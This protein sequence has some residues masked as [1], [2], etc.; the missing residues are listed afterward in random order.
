MYAG[1]YFNYIECDW[2]EIIYQ[3]A[4][5]YMQ[6]GHEDDFTYNLFNRNRLDIQFGLDGF[7]DI[8]YIN[9]ITGYEQYYHD[10]LGF[11]RLLYI[12]K[13]EKENYF[14]QYRIVNVSSNK[15]YPLSIRW[16]SNNTFS[17]D[18][19]KTETK[20]YNL[21]AP[22][23]YYISTDDEQTLLSTKDN[24]PLMVEGTTYT[25]SLIQAREKS[26][27]NI[28]DTEL[29]PLRQDKDIV[30]KH[31]NGYNVVYSRENN[32][33][34]RWPNEASACWRSSYELAETKDGI[35]YYYGTVHYYGASE[36]K[37]QAELLI[38]KANKILGN[39]NN[40]ENL[41]LKIEQGEELNNTELDNLQTY[42]D[43]FGMLNR[44]FDVEKTYVQEQ[45][46]I[47]NNIRIAQ[48]T[49]VQQLTAQLNTLA[50]QE[51][52]YSASI[53]YYQQMIQAASL[54]LCPYSIYF[55]QSQTK[56]EED[57]YENIEYTYNGFPIY[58]SY[59]DA[60]AHQWSS[61][62]VED[63]SSLLFWIDFWDADSLGLGQYSVPAIG[64]RPKVIN[65]EGIKVLIYQDVPDL[66]FVYEEDYKDSLL[67]N[68]DGYNVAILKPG[69]PFRE[70]LETRQIDRSSRSTTAQEEIDNLLYNYGYCNEDSTITTIPVYYLEPNNIIS[71]KDEQQIVN[72]YYILNKMTIPLSYNGTMQNNCIRVPERIY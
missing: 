9:G 60:I 71:A 25:L 22:Q 66:I 38:N 21:L 40:Y 31:I 27:Q 45:I 20:E 53:E 69:D 65:N 56:N 49:K 32:T 47:Q 28:I 57:F 48:T 55:D 7:K 39:L 30:S 72:G 14:S 2:R 54:A 8:H 36:L 5:D 6:Y 37:A 29:T 35:K 50:V 70:Y 51:A 16:N 41:L 18:A 64:A 1:K 67:D 43:I 10:M 33:I 3:M 15:K 26:I 52:G 68:Y 61:R 24:S 42:R 17:Y 12:P 11:W 46:G 58:T 13:D 59:E 23:E 4:L 34:T 63:P 62:I 44:D 19:N